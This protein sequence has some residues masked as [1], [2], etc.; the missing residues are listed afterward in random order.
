MF[1]CKNLDVAIWLK[2]NDIDL[3]I[4]DKD[5]IITFYA[6]D[7]EQEVRDRIAEYFLAQSGSA[8][9]IDYSKLLQATK[10]VKKKLHRE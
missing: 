3:E 7:A 10:W 6:N 5:E 8:I 9:N 2:A 1:K 4:E